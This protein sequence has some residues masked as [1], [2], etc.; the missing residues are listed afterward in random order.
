MTRS[1]VRLFVAGTE[2]TGHWRRQDSEPADDPARRDRRRRPA[3]TILAGLPAAM[4]AA[5]APGPTDFAILPPSEAGALLAQCSRGAPTAV[6]GVWQPAPQPIVALEALLP[7]ALRSRRAP[8]RPALAADLTRWQRQYVGIVRAGRRFVYGNFF[9]RR[10]GG[11]VWRTRA[12]VVCDGGSDYF[13]VEFDVA[14]GS[15]TRLDF[16][17]PV[18]L[19]NRVRK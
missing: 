17:G 14:A 12:I 15:V 13:G 8:G 5:M 1:L 9:P 19:E 2:R 6:Q 3:R 4:L 7:A 10:H 11:D 16:N 18:L